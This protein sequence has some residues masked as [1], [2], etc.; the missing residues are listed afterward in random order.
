MDKSESTKLLKREWFI[1]AILQ[2]KGLHNHTQQQIADNLG[3]SQPMVSRIKSG[4]V[5]L[6]DNI[7]TKVQQVYNIEGPDL[8][9]IS[10]ADP[11][12]VRQGSDRSNLE[13]RY[14][15]LERN[16]TDIRRELETT[17]SYIADLKE[18]IGFY[19]STMPQ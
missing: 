8:T 9:Q 15:L 16:M 11:A 3:V 2:I 10:A 17:Y 19:R 4:R 12:A 7:I 5:G 1:N 6:P 18:F 13:I 14:S